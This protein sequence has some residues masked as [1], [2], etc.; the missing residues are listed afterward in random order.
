METIN[1]NIS[2]YQLLNIVSEFSK[3]LEHGNNGIQDI[4]QHLN[5]KSFAGFGSQ[6]VHFTRLNSNNELV[7]DLMTGVDVPEEFRN[8]QFISLDSKL[9]IVDVFK[10][11]KILWINTLPDW[12][13]DYPLLKKYPIDFHGMTFIAIPLREGEFV[14]AVLSIVCEPQLFENVQINNFF[15]AIAGLISLTFGRP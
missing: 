10:S 11:G 15:M 3:F 9:P 8:N 12:G 2:A 1:E 4:L 7:L 14:K 5:R 13:I 6:S